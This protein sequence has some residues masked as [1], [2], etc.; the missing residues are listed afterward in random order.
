M[1]APAQDALTHLNQPELESRALS[2]ERFPHG[3]REA[4]GFML[5]FGLFCSIAREVDPAMPR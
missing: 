3:S 5:A 1:L 4:L 2:A